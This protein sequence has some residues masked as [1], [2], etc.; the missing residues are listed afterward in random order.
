M[1]SDGEFG[2]GPARGG[3]TVTHHQRSSPDGARRGGRRNNR[4]VKWPRLTNLNPDP[5][6][7]GAAWAPIR[8]GATVLGCTAE[9]DCVVRGSGVAPRHA[10]VCCSS[11][12]GVVVLCASTWCG[13]ARRWQQSRHGREGSHA[14]GARESRRARAA[15]AFRYEARQD[16]SLDAFDATD[17]W[18]AAI[19]EVSQKGSGAFADEFRGLSQL[20]DEEEAP[21]RAASPDPPEYTTA[22]AP[23]PVP[24]VVVGGG[25]SPPRKSGR[26]GSAAAR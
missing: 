26:A 21:A 1:S 19:A 2:R 23:D 8:D 4:E 6:F 22:R 3:L 24:R 13:D 14:P 18:H 12:Q 15:V 9:A 11:A 17:A 16:E 7:A 10:V 5:A 25:P 20:D